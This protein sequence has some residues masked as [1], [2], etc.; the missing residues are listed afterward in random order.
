MCDA[1]DL[2]NAALDTWTSS[3][4]AFKSAAVAG[5]FEWTADA[6]LLLLLL[7]L[8]SAFDG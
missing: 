7:L 1:A 4:S 8:G 6:L 2:A 5:T 3:I